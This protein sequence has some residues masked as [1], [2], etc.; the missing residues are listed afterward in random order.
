MLVA[1]IYYAKPLW[2]GRNRLF[3]SAGLI[4]AAF[5]LHFVLLVASTA[6]SGF[7][8]RT[9][10]NSSRQVVV[11][12]AL[13]LV[14]LTRP[15]AALFWHG[16]FAGSIGAFGIAVY[17]RFVLDWE[18]AEGFQMPIMFG[19]VAIAMGLMSL[20][21]IPHFARSRLAMLPYLTFL[22]AMATSLLSGARGGWI[23]LA[24]S[25]VPLYWYGQRAMR[26]KVV[27]IVVVS[28]VLSIASWF[29]P[30]LKVR[31]RLMDAT[32]EVEQYHQTGKAD[33]SVGARFEMWK[34][35]AIMF[36]EHPIFGVGRA[37][38]HKEMNVLIA[39]GDIDP[40]VSVFRHAHNELLDA[41][42]NGGIVGALALLF[43]Y[44][45][46]LAFFFRVLRRRDDAKPYALAGLLL[47]LS[48]IGF[49]LTQ[50]LFAHHIG[51]AFYAVTVCMLAG[52]CIMLQQHAKPAPLSERPAMAET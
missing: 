18:R 42:A 44:A 36:A 4:I 14:V 17:Q 25:F 9:L 21:A 16:L 26:H 29:V 11:L 27:V 10:D 20:A 23:A 3:Q 38:Y 1:T 48:Y 12:G 30:E 47:V 43:L 19:D 5:V 13:G 49:G 28:A 52:I 8:L 6:W 22:A 7:S 31:E 35:A 41:M 33:T 32:A 50:V 2:L 34:G 37:N 40:A 46:P 51:S 24:I 15:R 45:A 39:N